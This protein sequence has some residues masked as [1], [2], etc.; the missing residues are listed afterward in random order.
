MELR[1]RY[2]HRLESICEAVMQLG[3]AVEQSLT[4]AMHSLSTQNTAVA[5]W[6][7]ENDTQID[8]Q[9]YTLDEQIV[10]M[11][12]TDQPIVSHDL[13][14][15]M[16]V[17]AIVTEL[18][19]IGDYAHGIAR[20]VHD[21]PTVMTQIEIPAELSQMADLTQQML[22]ASLEAFLHEDAEAARSLKQSEEAVDA[23]RD[24]LQVQLK[25]VARAD[26]QHLDTAIDL[27]YVVHALERSADR[28]TNI[29]ERVI[30]VVTNN[31]ETLNP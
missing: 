10:S 28:A 3:N 13:R 20:R 1:K 7:M 14:L 12:A 16:S 25:D 2:T 29:A 31:T 8:T 5:L 21:R 18:E 24:Q 11:F 23:L 26:V 19:R 30:Y 22:R 27:L 4:R 6:V 9:R 15:L 17:S